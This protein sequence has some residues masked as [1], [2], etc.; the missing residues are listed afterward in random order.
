[1]PKF[2]TWI[3][4]GSLA[5]LPA[6]AATSYL[7]KPTLA[8]APSAHLCESDMAVLSIEHETANVAECKISKDGAFQLTILPENVPINNSPWYGFRVDPR[9][10]GEIT[11]SLRYE[12]GD[13]RYIPKVSFDEE[14]W[15]PISE[16]QI[17]KNEKS[18][19]SFTLAIDDQPFLVSAQEI[20]TVADHEAWMDMAVESFGLESRI[21]GQSVDGHPIRAVQTPLNPEKAFLILAGR[22]HPPELTGA[23]A[24]EPF[25]ETVFGDTDLAKQFRETF[26]IIAVPL[27]NPDGVAA[28]YWRHNKGG[29]D[30][31]RDWGPF[32]QPETQSMRDL[33]E[34]L[35]GD[36]LDVRLFLDFHST[37]QNL[38]YT[39]TD[40]E[41][42]E[43]PMFAGRWVETVTERTASLNYPFV[44]RPSPTS[45][46]GTSKNYMYKRYGIPAI[47]YEVGDN[48]DREALE[49]A[50]VIFAEE[51]MGLLMTSETEK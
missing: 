38:L 2:K 29:L 28:G 25:M 7:L 33:I 11:I 26:N 6:C 12:D 42:T 18:D 44:R 35:G 19:F 20:I 17:L 43:P 5:V 51:M 50:A 14:N 9:S 8:T 24:M 48:A 13:H 37:H 36:G 27:L 34:E 41:P 1:M 16:G 32:T 3:L 40:E 31:N 10:S 46:R 39:Q 30:L 15:R 4:L 22:Q 47:T 49:M 21:I 23:L 45:N